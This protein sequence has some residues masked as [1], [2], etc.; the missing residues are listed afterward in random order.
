MKVRLTERQWSFVSI[1]AMIIIIAATL[2]YTNTRPDPYAGVPIRVAKTCAK[3]VIAFTGG[4][5]GQILQA[6]GCEGGALHRGSAIQPRTAG[7]SR[8]DVVS[9]RADYELSAYAE[10]VPGTFGKPFSAPEDAK[11]FSEP[12][13]TAYSWTSIAYHRAGFY[14]FDGTF[15]G[16]AKILDVAPFG[17]TWFMTLLAVG[18]LLLGIG[19]PTISAWIAAIAKRV[20]QRA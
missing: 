16:V 10:Q 20:F 4:S 7:W 1:I 14:Y 9:G 15:E 6:F 18:G 2:S 3:P 12:D 17:A 8:R 5:A 19:V 13:G 11:P